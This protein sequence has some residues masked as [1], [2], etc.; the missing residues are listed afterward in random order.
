MVVSEPLYE[1]SVMELPYPLPSVSE[2]SK[3]AGA[4]MVTS[5]LS[6]LVPSTLKD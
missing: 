6:K 4:V 1:E 3:L 2:I 5:E